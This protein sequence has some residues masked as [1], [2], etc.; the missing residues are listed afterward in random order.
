M[1]DSAKVEAVLYIFCFFFFFDFWFYF[2]FAKACEH[3]RVCGT[4]YFIS[5]HTFL[6][7]MLIFFFFLGSLFCVQVSFLVF[8][9]FFYFFEFCNVFF[10]FFCTHT[11]ICILKRPLNFF[12]LFYGCICF[13][14]YLFSRI[15]VEKIQF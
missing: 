14:V 1:N 15:S 4:V 5:N 8:C 13:E 11:Y 2:F 10:F 6:A 9:F 3:K 12:L 7:L